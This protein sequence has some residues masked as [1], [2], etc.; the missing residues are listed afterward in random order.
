MHD[1]CHVHI[2]DDGTIRVLR[3]AIE[4]GQI[5]IDSREQ[6][7]DLGHVG[8]GVRFR[9]GLQVDEWVAT[10]TKNWQ[11]FHSTKSG[12]VA[13]LLAA[14]GLTEVGEASTIEGLF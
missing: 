7:Y 8:M 2:T 5:G 9:K 14:H 11:H 4:A 6:W 12:A 10:S 13:K 1:P 3:L